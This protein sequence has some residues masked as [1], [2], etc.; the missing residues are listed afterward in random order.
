MP[1]SHEAAL[2]GLDAFMLEKVSSAGESL[3]GS[4]SPPRCAGRRPLD[5]P[6]A[7]K[8]VLRSAPP[9]RVRVIRGEFRLGKCPLGV[10]VLVVADHLIPKCWP[11]TRDLITLTRW[12]AAN[13]FS[14]ASTSRRISPGRRGCCRLSQ[15]R[16]GGCGRR[17]GV[18]DR[19]RT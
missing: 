6:T 4:P 1:K 8:Q 12:A 10:D 14:L 2:E 18:G 11:Q 9:T 7:T 13:W 17:R 3:P 19:A 16:V 15:C 5:E